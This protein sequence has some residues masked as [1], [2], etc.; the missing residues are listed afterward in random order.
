MSAKRPL[1]V[2][3]SFGKWSIV[4]PTSFYRRGTRYVACQ[5]A[6]GLVKDVVVAHLVRGRSRACQSCAAKQGAIGRAKSAYRGTP[7]INLQHGHALS[8]AQ[9]PTYRSWQ[10]MLARCENPQ[11]SHW[12]WYGGR[13]VTV[14][15][16]WH[17]F[18]NFLA[19][20]GER[21]PG[22]TLD[23]K[24]NA[25]GYCPDNCRWATRKEQQRN[26][27]RNRLITFGGMTHPLV[28]WTEITGLS[29]VCLRW[30]LDHGWSIEDALTIPSGGKRVKHLS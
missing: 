25:L 15:E 3:Q 24:E 9:S 5:C 29:W 8:G 23:R 11:H 6:C 18:T 20:M 10:A 26:R 4:D 30:R 21:P 17:D 19:D 12:H 2:G 13:G 16:H 27:T 22:K 7:P 1:A 14:C 28:V